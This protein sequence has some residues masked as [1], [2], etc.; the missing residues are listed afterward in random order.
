M[1]NRDCLAKVLW[2][3]HFFAL[4]LILIGC[5][6]ENRAPVEFDN[7]KVAVYYVIPADENLNSFSISNIDRYAN[8]IQSWYQAATG[9]V[10]FEYSVN[11]SNEIVR[12]YQ[13]RQNKDF[14][15]DDWWNLLLEEMI[16]ADLAVH[17]NGTIVSVWIEGVDFLDDGIKGLGQE[18][19]E[20]KCG[21]AMVGV[22]TLFGPGRDNEIII[23]IHELGHAFGLV[24]PIES[25][26]SQVEGAEFILL[27]SIMT[28]YLLVT[29]PVIGQLGFLTG[30]KEILYSSPFLKKDLQV[31]QDLTQHR[32][33]NYP[34]TDSLPGTHFGVQIAGKEIQIL[35]STVNVVHYFWNFGDGI[36]STQSNPRH[37]F[38]LAGRYIIRLTATSAGFMTARRFRVLEIED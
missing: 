13:A 38:E 31:S 30:E 2:L 37:T 19:C 22:E 20:S 16:D 1:I 11:E 33:L 23:P 8:R 12:I 3:H 34:V 24:H 21:V 6:D 9:G 7:F 25:T 17:R 10:T 29:N 32:V 4:T 18:M 26:S 27:S 35:D 14:Y 15:Q 36:T 28:P 5:S